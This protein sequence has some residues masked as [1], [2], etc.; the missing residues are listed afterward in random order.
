MMMH[1]ANAMDIE[2]QIV[3][4]R[5]ADESTRY[6]LVNALKRELSKLGKAERMHAIL[7]LKQQMEAS[8][9]KEGTKMTALASHDSK[10]E[11]NSQH[12]ILEKYQNVA[13][14]SS[15]EMGTMEY[16]KGGV[17]G[18]VLDAANAGTV[19]ATASPETATI[20]NT[21]V[22]PSR[23]T[24]IAVGNAQQIADAATAIQQESVMQQTPAAID[25]IMNNAAT[26]ILQENSIQQNMRMLS[27]RI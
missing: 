16:T 14:V 24:E 10:S 3:K 20:I 9:S 2:A 18:E 11:Q 1:S 6:Q 21:Q 23:P 7:A 25:H 15:V 22:T 19:I 17:G 27:Y 13:A 5:Q 26:T 8:S 12:N 4:I